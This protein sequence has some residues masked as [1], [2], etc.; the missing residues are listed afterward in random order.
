MTSPARS[1]CRSALRCISPT[2]TGSRRPGRTR[3]PPTTRRIDGGR[4]CEVVIV[5]VVEDPHGELP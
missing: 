3:W 4:Q 2:S 5:G 1:S